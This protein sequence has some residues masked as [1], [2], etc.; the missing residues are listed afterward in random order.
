[1]ASL[2]SYCV[3]LLSCPN[4]WVKEFLLSPEALHIGLLIIKRNFAHDLTLMQ[5]ALYLKLAS[6][7]EIKKHVQK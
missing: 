4:L 6:L 7:E 5:S 3:F 1:M 2:P